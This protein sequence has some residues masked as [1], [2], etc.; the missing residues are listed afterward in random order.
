LLAGQRCPNTAGVSSKACDQVE[1]VNGFDHRKHDPI[2]GLT[3]SSSPDEIRTALLGIDLSDPLKVEPVL[4]LVKI[5]T[6]QPIAVL[7]KVFKGLRRLPDRARPAW[8]ST[9]MLSPEGDPLPIAANIEIALRH[10]EAWEGVLAFDEFHQRPMLLRRPP[11]ARR[12]KG[13]VPFSDADEARTLVWVQRQGI[14]ARIEA[15]RQ[16]LAIIVD[17]HRYHPVRDYLSGIKWD[18]T[19]RLDGWLTYY[20]GADDIPDY[21]IPVGTRW[22][23]SAVARIFQPGCMAKYAMILEGPQDLKKSAALEVLGTPWFTDDVDELGSK[24]SKL[25]VGNA[26]IIELAELDSMRRAEINAIKSFISRKVDRFR[27]PF[28]RYI[29]EQPRQ[30]VL[31]GTV[32]PSTEYFNDD[33]GAVRF[34]PIECKSIDLDALT[35]DRDQLWAEATA[36]YKIGERWWLDV[37]EMVDAA[38]I[39]QEHR[40]ASDSWEDNIKRWLEANPII[41]QVTTGEILSSV[42]ELP[43]SEHDKAKQTRV[44]M[45]LRRLN[46]SRPKL[47]RGPNGHRGSRVY[48]RPEVVTNT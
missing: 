11:W 29:T 31:A 13:P 23:I 38:S 48:T 43:P 17:D 4:R 24:D 36:R 5:K 2:D 34:W 35:A 1:T 32:N 6:G 41:D 9:I 3:K 40:Y 18:G 15:V 27:K 8:V 22:M 10:D 16:A 26:W 39:Q 42:F 14:I 20:L 46:W 7:R 47:V 25:Q 45:I 33:T 30:C 28:G 12:W 19:P 37:K 21:T 44:G